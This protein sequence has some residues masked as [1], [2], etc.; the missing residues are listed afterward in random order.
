MRDYDAIM[1]LIG[2]LLLTKLF[3]IAMW[4]YGVFTSLM[5]V[6]CQA[7]SVSLR[8]EHRLDSEKFEPAGT[9]EGIVSEEVNHSHSHSL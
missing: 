7:S 4:R 5:L 6:S 8:L 2:V 1:W 9:I 3:L